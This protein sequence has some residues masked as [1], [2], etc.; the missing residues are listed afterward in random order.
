MLFSKEHRLIAVPQISNRVYELR[1]S[2]GL[3]AAELA[4][5]VG[6]SRQT[7]YAIEAGNYVPNT[8]T[9]LQMARVLQV[10]VEELFSLANRA[11][12]ST[13][14]VQAELLCDPAD[15]IGDGPLVQL[16]R[17]GRSLVASA[18]SPIPAYLPHADGLIERKSKRRVSV[19]AAGEIPENGKRLLLAG[20]DPALSVLSDLV[21][22]SSID[23]VT[24]PCSSKKALDCLAQHRVHAA[25]SHLRDRHSGE[26]N[27]PFVKKLFPRG[28]M[29]VITF[30]VWEQGLVVR[31]GN[32]KG[33]RTIADLA[34]KG[35]AIVNREK[36]SGSRDLLDSGLANSGIS[37]SS[38][39]GYECIAQGHLAAAYAVASG[40]DDCCIATRSAARRFGLDFIPLAVERFDLSV[41]KDSLEL[42]AMKALLDTLNRSM[43]RRKLETIAGYDATHTGDL[44]I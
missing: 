29:R 8:V 34:G 9:A 38:V 30:A 33:I 39:R 25:G 3:S 17:V 26:Y 31:R 28:G 11:E 37:E 1:S 21:R 15:E 4:K 2:R 14:P 27:V 40:A 36:G 24:V 19:R 18:V 10:G 13:E 20:C 42:P 41:G 35:I 43:L 5:H 23:I 22:S 7:I 16:C 12:Q 44:L 6:V 32:P